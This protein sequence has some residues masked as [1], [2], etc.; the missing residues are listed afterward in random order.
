MTSGSLTFSTYSGLSDLDRI[1]S[2]VASCWQRLGVNTQLHIGNLGWRLASVDLTGPYEG[3]GIWSNDEGRVVALALV[4]DLFPVDLLIDPQVNPG[5]ELTH[6]LLD[7]TE[8]RWRSAVPAGPAARRLCVGCLESD[9]LRRAVLER[10]GYAIAERSYLRFA[11]PIADLSVAA[12]LPEG[13]CLRALKVPQDVA[14]LVALHNA[15]FDAPLLTGEDCERIFAAPWYR[16]KLCC[17]VE[18]PAGEPVSFALGWIDALGRALEFEPVG[19]H[20]DWRRKGITG[21]L[22]HEI[23]RRAGM[24]GAVMASVTARADNQDTIAFYHAAGFRNHMTEYVFVES[25]L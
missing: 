20:P 10:R 19:C 5:E 8:S 4:Y 17:L 1:R 23:M 21:A 12:N 18:G 14:R 13:L 25:S 2:M 22:L 7:W 6:V 15:V 24:A 3:I 16:Q 9:A 11:C